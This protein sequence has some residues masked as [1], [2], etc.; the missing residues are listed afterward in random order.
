MWDWKDRPSE[1]YVEELTVHGEFLKGGGKRGL[2]SNA[3]PRWPLDWPPSTVNVAPLTHTH[4]HTSIT[5]ISVRNVKS[6]FI[7]L[8]IYLPFV[9]QRGYSKPTWVN[10]IKKIMEK[11]NKGKA[12]KT[13]GIF[14]IT[15]FVSAGQST[16]Y[17]WDHFKALRVGIT[18]YYLIEYCHE[19]STT[20]LMV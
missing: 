2:L 3:E 4:T 10:S 15:L 19:T 9:C 17:T 12:H 20:I 5:K 13:L 14:W 7:Y 1:Q 18:E 6:F 16:G 8:F 11:R